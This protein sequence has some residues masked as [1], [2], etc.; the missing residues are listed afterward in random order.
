MNKKF[1]KNIEWPVLIASILLFV[2]G[3]FGIYSATKNTGLEEFYK[4]IQWFVIS[5]PFFI[6]FLVVDYKKIAQFSPIMYIVSI[7]LLVG[8]LFT[9]PINGASSWYNFAG[10]SFQPSET[11]KV[12]TIIFSAYILA[13]LQLKGKTEINKIYKLALIVLI[14]LLPTALIVIQPD[15]GTA[16]TYLVI[17]VF[18]LFIAGIGKRY[19]IP[20][21]IGGCVLAYFAYTYILPKYAP[22]ALNRIEVFLN[23]RNRS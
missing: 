19:I 21:I 9:E 3:L 7:I 20:V 1:L 23:P 13:I 6:L 14:V 16:V 15:N 2:I 8:V 22:Y 18:M 11:A 4:Q 5:I 17:L 12:S 10:M